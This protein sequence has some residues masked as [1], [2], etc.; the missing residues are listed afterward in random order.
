MFAR[1]A[2]NVLYGTFDERRVEDCRG[3][4]RR[5]LVRTYVRTSNILIGQWLHTRRNVIRET[6]NFSRCR[7]NSSLKSSL[8]GADNV[9][10]RTTVTLRSTAGFLS[11]DLDEHTYGRPNPRREISTAGRQL[12]GGI[13]QKSDI[14]QDNQHNSNHGRARTRARETT[15]MKVA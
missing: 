5:S 6:M 2:T 11:R 4:G 7:N 9:G 3:A 14:R 1:R 10:S 12:D 8:G 13:A 15:L